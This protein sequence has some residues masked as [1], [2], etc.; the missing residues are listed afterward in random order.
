MAKMVIQVE[1]DNYSN[2]TASHVQI[3]CYMGKI[4]Q[5]PNIW[6]STKLRVHS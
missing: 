1:L 5:V 4:Q 3:A 2:A 6:M